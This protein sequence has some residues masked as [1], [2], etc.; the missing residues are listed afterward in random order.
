VTTRV[1]IAEDES[2]IRLDLAEMLAEEGYAVVGETGRGDEVLE[3]VRS[4][5]PDLAILDVKMPG[6][7]GLTV[8]RQIADEALCGVIIL[9][10]FSQRALIEAARDAG[11]FAYL[12]KPFQKSELIAAVEVAVGRHRQMQALAEEVATL[13]ER[14]EVR[15]A[16]DR[17][18]G[19]LML[20]LGVGEPEAFRLLQR[21]AMD[22]RTTMKAVAE[23]ILQEDVSASGRS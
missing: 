23:M 15:K 12:V 11:V 3:L 21:R 2:I 22:G 20:R 17:A 13:S 14:L 10:A 19:L 7:D 1:L 5:T 6:L 8:A 16:V 4:L 18:K 9:T